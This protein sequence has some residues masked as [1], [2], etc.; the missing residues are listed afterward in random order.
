MGVRKDL[1]ELK[2]CDI[3]S[4]VLFVLYKI[5]DIPEY[6]SL[7][8]MIYLMPKEAVLTLCEY[9]GGMTLKIP[10]IDELESVLLATLLYKYIKI[11]GIE[12]EDAVEKMGYKSRLPKEI[13]T[14]YERLVEVLNNYEFKP[15]G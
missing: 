14:T 1:L 6:G 8:E 4:M 10:T 7:C 5:K 15:R 9:W 3:W 13:R 11:D 2:E 12:Y